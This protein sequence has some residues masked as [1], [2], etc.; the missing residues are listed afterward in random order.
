MYRT[1]LN[2]YIVT[3][4]VLFLVNDH[5]VV[6]F[7]FKILYLVLSRFDTGCPV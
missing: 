5:Q 2:T 1:S 4:Y 7:S 3:N 6:K